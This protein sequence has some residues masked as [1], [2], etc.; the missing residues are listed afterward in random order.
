MKSLFYKIIRVAGL[1]FIPVFLSFSLP[2][3]WFVAGSMPGSYEMIDADGIAING[4]QTMTIKSIKKKVSGFGTLM[5]TQAAGEY[6][7]SRVRMTG[8]M[9][10]ENVKGWA[11]FWMRIDSNEKNKYLGFDNM[12][13]G[14][15]DRSINGSNEWQ[16]YEIVLDVP[17]GSTSLN[18]GALLAGSGQI[19]F[20][21]VQFEKVDSS[22][23]TTGRGNRQNQ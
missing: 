4:K 19:W 8:M 9:K 16:Q 2:K 7:G 6:I 3:G 22:V 21:D 5:K 23:K 13:D 15:E 17:E 10:T 18:F 20:G 11:G 1:V 14:A 12:K